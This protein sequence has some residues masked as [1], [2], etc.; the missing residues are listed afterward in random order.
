MLARRK[1]L[2]P[3]AQLNNNQQ[4]KNLNLIDVKVDEVFYFGATKNHLP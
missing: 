3:V 2:N 4:L 1:I